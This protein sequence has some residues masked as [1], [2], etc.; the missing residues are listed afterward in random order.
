MFGKNIGYSDH[1]IGSEASIVA[2]SKGAKIIEKHITLNTKM[3]GPDHSS[4]LPVK[5]L[6]KFIIS[7]K[8]IK[9][10]F[11]N[12]IKSISQS[13]KKNIRNVR[14]SIVAKKDILKGEKFTTKNLSIKRPGFGLP[15]EYLNNLINKKSKYNFKKDQL[16]EI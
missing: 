4:S 9:N 15:L 11:R 1:T 6:K 5:N 13:E 10:F 14:K 7:L 2:V 8:K 16:I 3:I 12:N